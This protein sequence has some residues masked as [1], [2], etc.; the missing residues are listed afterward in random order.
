LND[1]APSV[2]SLAH[3]NHG[4]VLR[5]MAEVTQRRVAELVGVSESVLS[6]FK[7]QH[8]E[9]LCAVIAASGLRIAPC[10]EHNY[11]DEYIDALKVQA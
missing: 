3:R 11:P 10:T 6:E 8:L 5:G 2:R 4:M 1:L 9:R 7:S